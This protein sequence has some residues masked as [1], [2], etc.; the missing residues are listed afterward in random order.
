VVAEVGGYLGLT[1]GVSAMDIV[2]WALKAMLALLN[3]LGVRK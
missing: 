2:R 3:K 1:L